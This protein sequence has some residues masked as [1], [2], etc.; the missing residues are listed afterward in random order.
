MN[1]NIKKIIAIALALSFAPALMPK[2]LNLGTTAVYA[3]SSSGYITDI[4]LRTNK[5]DTENVY[6]KSNCNS[7]YKLSK[8][9]GK[10]PTQLY[11]EVDRNVKK[12][13][14]SD[15]DY[16]TDCDSVK[17]Y[18]GSTKIDLDEEVKISNTLRLKIEAYKGSTL[19]ETYT[20]KIVKEDDNDND[21]DDDD[22][23]D[24]YLDDLK[25]EYDNDDIDFDFDKD[26]K[27]FD[28]DVKN[29]VDYVKIIADPDSNSD[30]V[31]IHGDT[32]T[33]DDD[34]KK[35][36]SLSEGKNTI[37]VKVKD[38]DSNKREY[39]LNIT[40]ASSSTSSSSDNN[41]SSTSSS[42]NTNSSSTSNLTTVLSEGWQQI[43]ANWYF[44]APDGSKQTGWQK[45]DG[46]WYYMN[47]SGVMQTGWLKSSSSGKSY[48][49]NPISNGYKGAMVT[50][51]TIEGY[52]IGS[53]GA[54]I[55]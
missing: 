6:T 31:R 54:R 48:Y 22:D 29:K 49:L 5:D 30:T 17:I 19:K 50:N 23:D 3:A 14:V 10:A 45:V 46:K 37:I 1:K 44:I 12:V 35:K 42:S 26:K 32:V 39:E 2:G 33:D 55:N 52:T 18:D 4:T 13:K 47:E 36:V 41:S 28:I 9:S 16:G 7:S 21:D 24:V 8:I 51:K 27:S 38:D 40:R 53:D 25:L 43:N 20:I 34:W 11:A 15:I